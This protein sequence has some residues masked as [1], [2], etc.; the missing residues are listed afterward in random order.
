MMSV[1]STIILLLMITIAFCVTATVVSSDIFD[2]V[3][4]SLSL[5]VAEGALLLTAGVAY[6][7][8]TMLNM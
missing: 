2:W 3:T 4:T 5:T 6:E 7:T 1:P 8:K